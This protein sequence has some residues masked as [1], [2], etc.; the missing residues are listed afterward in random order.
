MQV[1][2]N[3]IRCNK[4]AFLDKQELIQNVLEWWFLTFKT[5]SMYITI[6]GLINGADMRLLFISLAKLYNYKWNISHLRIVWLH[7][8]HNYHQSPIFSFP[9]L[10]DLSIFYQLYFKPSNLDNVITT[11]M[12]MCNFYSR[13]NWL[14][15]S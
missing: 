12:T 9:C 5:C 15:A 11:H 4:A 2:Q 13:G 8:Q 3:W 14:I 7:E 1:S 6:D 10:T